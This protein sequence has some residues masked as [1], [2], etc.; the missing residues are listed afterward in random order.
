MAAEMTRV[1]ATVSVAGL[2]NQAMP[3]TGVITPETTRDPIIKRAIKS[4][5]RRSV[6]KRIMAPKMTSKVMMASIPINPIKNG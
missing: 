5:E 3:S 2:L 1:N 6:T 4:I